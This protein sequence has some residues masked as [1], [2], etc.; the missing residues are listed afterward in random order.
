M[1]VPQVGLS[2]HYFKFHLNATCMQEISNNFT[3]KFQVVQYVKEHGNREAENHFGPPP[4][5][6]MYCLKVLIV[7][8]PHFIHNQAT[9]EYY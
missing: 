8:I 1:G 6:M 3:C 9:T 5:K 4:T 2:E 7:K